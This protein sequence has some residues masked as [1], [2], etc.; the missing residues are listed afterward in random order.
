MPFGM[1]TFKG[2]IDLRGGMDFASIVSI[3]RKE[4]C[5]VSIVKQSQS[6][7]SSRSYFNRRLVS[8]PPP[9]P[10]LPRRWMCTLLTTRTS[11]QLAAA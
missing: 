1:V 5:G 7:S 2:R 4:V 10:S 3:A 6:M 11:P 8:N 9:F